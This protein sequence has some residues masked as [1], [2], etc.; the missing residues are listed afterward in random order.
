MSI[1]NIKEILDC[2]LVTNGMVK[3]RFKCEYQLCGLIFNTKNDVFLCKNCK[4]IVCTQCIERSG[5]YCLNCMNDVHKCQP[6]F[7]KYICG[8][9]GIITCRKC[10]SH[11]GIFYISPTT[12]ILCITCKK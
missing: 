1:Q 4:S 8:K 3:F 12:K 7:P 6:R 11:A 10:T 2:E 9:C 5:K